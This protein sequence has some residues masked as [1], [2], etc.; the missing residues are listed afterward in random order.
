MLHSGAFYGVYTVS[1]LLLAL[2]LGKGM[3]SQE[4]GTYSLISSVVAVLPA[5]VSFSAAQYYTREVPGRTAEESASIFKSIVAVQ[6]AL[7]AGIC[8]IL[9]LV[10]PA[11]AWAENILGIPGRWR[12]LLLSAGI[13]LADSLATDLMR[14]LFARCEIERG[15]IVSFI[16]ASL[17]PLLLFAAVLKG[18]PITLPI[19][20]IS[21]FSGA[22]AA[23]IA[24]IFLADAKLLARAPVLM[25]TYLKA[26]RFSAPYLFIYAPLAVQTFGRFMIAGVYSTG[27]VGVYAYQYNIIAMI[28]ALA[29]PFVSAPLEPYITEAFNRGDPI[30][31]GTLLGTAAKYRLAVVIPLL[32]IACV[33]HEQ[34][35]RILAKQDF[36]AVPWLMAALA[37]IPLTMTLSATFERVLFL[38]RKTWKIGSSYA[39]SALIQGIALPICVPLHPQYGPALA[40]NIGVFSQL[41]LMWIHA[42]RENVRLT[43]GAAPLAVSGLVAVALAFIPMRW[44]GQAGDIY[45]LVG[46]LVMVGAGYAAAACA[47]NILSVSERQVL[48]SF[49]RQNGKRLFPV[50]EGRIR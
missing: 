43:I 22:A 48:G 19:V 3:S 13:F 40:M 37:P 34:L 49:L 18:I 33:G 24:G 35:I 29:G 39:I 14:L 17:W 2:A 21:W 23:V 12:L 41:A 20:L 27:A 32:A 50:L 15:N 25:S 9:I 46:A 47:L 36:T 8:A 45:A 7:L 31:S 11:R 28:G 42:R 38:H 26:I 4:Y 16:Q 5:L 1:R 6:A 10:P 30:R 44:L